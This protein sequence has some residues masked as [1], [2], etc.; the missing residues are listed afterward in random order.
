MT[1]P[2]SIVLSREH[3][4]QFAGGSAAPGAVPQ[5]LMMTRHVLVVGASFSDDNLLRLLYEVKQLPVPG[6]V[7]RTIGTVLTPVPDA[8]RAE[9]L[10]QDF[11]FIAAG[12]QVEENAIAYRAVEIE[13]DHIGI[14]ACSDASYALDPDFDGLLTP[15]E[16][17]VADSLRSV[18]AE[19]RAIE[20]GKQKIDAWRL[21]R[22]ALE[23]FGAPSDSWQ[24]RS[25]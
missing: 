13:L 19:V 1:D 8:A 16:S 17:A 6:G 22:G 15:E 5:S 10:G 2:A 24:G 18:L 23:S 12:Q 20:R 7:D 25:G 11:D 3:F 14:L 9:I 21:I 4:V